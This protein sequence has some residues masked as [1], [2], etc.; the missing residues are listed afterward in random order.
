MALFGNNLLEKDFNIFFPACTIDCSSVVQII[1]HHFPSTICNFY[2]NFLQ[3]KYLIRCLV[4]SPQKINFRILCAWAM[5]D[6]LKNK[7]SAVIYFRYQLHALLSSNNIYQNKNLYFT[8]YI[9]LHFIYFSIFPFFQRIIREFIGRLSFIHI[10]DD[11]GTNP[12]DG[13][14]IKQS[15]VF[16][17]FTKIS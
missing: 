9:L 15:A 4:S 10:E 16:I 11:R 5:S 1:T 3:K 2:N 13:I 14:I 17:A 7:T 8:F 12:E 6:I